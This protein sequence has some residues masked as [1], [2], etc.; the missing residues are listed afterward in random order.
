MFMR[1]GLGSLACLAAAVSIASA[2]T[3]QMPT[4]YPPGNFHTQNIQAFADQVK[5]DTGGKL[6]IVVHPGGSL[7]P[8]PQIKRNVQSGDIRIGEV[9]LPGLENEAPVFGMDAV[10]FVVT[11][12]DRAK[13]LWDA[14]R[15]LVEAQLKGQG[16]RVLYAVPWPPQG[17]YANR[18]LKSVADMRG[19]RFRSYGPSAARFGELAGLSVSTIQAAE[20]S[21]ALATGRINAMLTSP[22]TGVDSRVWETSVK[23]YYDIQAFLP[24]NAVIVNEAAFAALDAPVRDAVLAAARA[25]E[26]RGWAASQAAAQAAT[27]T[28]AAN[29]VRVLEPSAELKRDLARIGTQLVEDWGK[30]A[31]PEATAVLGRFRQ[32]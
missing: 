14:S 22:V 26:T 13:Q 23:F 4:G 16:I 17:L 2:E 31:G 28:L 12:Y 15:P 1:L 10:P 19:L 21:E 7:M 25:A 11:G 6:E 29:G 3:W 8:L 24:K 5:A 20:L 18:E 32:E 30:R 27:Q 9:F